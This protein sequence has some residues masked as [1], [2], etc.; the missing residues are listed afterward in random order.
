[1]I[2][3]TLGASLAFLIGRYAGRGMVEK[4]VKGKEEFEKIDEGVRKQG[5]RMLMITRLV[6]VF[7][8]N[9]QNFAYGLTK[10]DFKTYVFVSA[11]SM[12][13]G[14]IAFTFMAGAIVSGEGIGKISVYIGIG[15]IFF[16]II[17][18]IPKWIKK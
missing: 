13:P 12:I 9:L 4:W 18:L 11:I 1:M 16:V 15:A 10:I 6:P 14:I 17:S 5:W 3:A 8:F 7:P 2:G